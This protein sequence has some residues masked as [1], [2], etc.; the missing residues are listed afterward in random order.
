MQT[1][2]GLVFLTEALA[3]LADLRE[4]AESTRITQIAS[5]ILFADVCD[6]VQSSVE[7]L[8]AQDRAPHWEI[9]DHW[10]RVFK[11][12]ERSGFPLPADFV[13]ASSLLLKK[14]ESDIALM[15]PSERDE[16]L[17]KLEAT[18]HK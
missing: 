2:E 4:A 6:K 7:P 10:G 12:F 5:N 13:A 9:V 3:I 1:P 15:S 8:L 17:E 11:E 14:V 16:L 18:R